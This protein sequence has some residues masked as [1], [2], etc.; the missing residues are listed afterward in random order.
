MA[1]SLPALLVAL[2]LCVPAS[3]WAQYDFGKNRVVYAP[4]KWRIYRTA[5]FDLHY[6]ASMEGVAVELAQVAG[7]GVARLSATMRHRLT[8][9]VPI[10]VYPSATAFANTALSPEVIDEGTGGF[11][12][13]QRDRVVVPFTGK[14][15]EFRHV[16][17]HELAHA[18][19][20]SILENASDGN[21][22]A[23][24]MPGLWAMEGLA[25]FASLGEDETSRAW[26]RD[27]IL[28]E[29]MPGLAE[30]ENYWTLGARAFY[31]YKAG[32][33][34]FAW[35]ARRHGSNAPGEL[36]QRLVRSNDP[37]R[38]FKEVTG[39]KAEEAS[40]LWRQDL[41]ERWWPS[42][43][44]L[45]DPDLRDRRVT[46]ATRDGSS[47]NLRPVFGTN[48]NLVY[49]ISNRKVYAQILLVD[50]DEDRVL[51]VVASADREAAF[52]SINVL[53]NTLSLTADRSRLCFTSRDRGAYV[54]HLWD[55]RSNRQAA[56]YALPMDF[57]AV[58]ESAVSPDGS[59]IAFAA[60]RSNQIDLWL[61]DP[62]APS[63]R[64]LTDDAFVEGEPAWSPDGRHL[65]YTGNRGA[66]KYSTLR[67]LYLRDLATGEDRLLTRG[68]GIHHCPS[69]SPDGKRVAFISDRGGV[70]NIWIKE[71]STG[72]T[73]RVTDLP[74]EALSV[75]W[76]QDG[77][78]LAYG[79]LQAGLHDVFIRNLEPTNAEA[80]LE[81][82]AE[83][84]VA[85]APA[86]AERDRE[87]EA[88][89]PR[90]RLTG[91][92]QNAYRA[93]LV[94]D[95]FMLMAGGASAYGFSL[96]AGASF[97][98]M[99][100]E[101]RLNASLGATYLPGNDY[102]D[103]A[104]YL[105]YRSLKNRVNWGVAGWFSRRNLYMPDL[106]SNYSISNTMVEQNAG[107]SAMAIYPFSKYSRLEASLSPTFFARSFRGTTTE[108]V[109]NLYP[110]HAPT[111]SPQA[112]LAWIF[113]NTLFGYLHPVDNSRA[114]VL[115]EGAPPT[116]SNTGFFRFMA[117][118]RRYFMLGR[119]ASLALRLMLGA[120]VG[121]DSAEYDFKIGGN[122]TLDFLYFTSENY[123]TLHSLPP[124]SLRGNF[125]Q[126][127]NVEYRFQFLQA[128]N[129]SWPFPF[130]IRNI[131]GVV[132]F[133]AGAAT[134]N[135]ATLRAWSSDSNGV[136][137]HDLK[138]A[139]GFGFRFVFLI[140]PMKVDFSTPWDGRTLRDLKNWDV[141][142]S[143]G[144]DY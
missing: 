64:R 119:R 66:T 34:F 50:V 54:F 70:G 25:E 83:D 95:A 22:R 98:D 18:F 28:S 88:Y 94:P 1:R 114:A 140:F 129:F 75:A 48:R 92:S 55:T 89:R 33:S 56:A 6:D 51:R 62:S 96:S 39:R 84:P 139:F 100:G 41:R 47:I 112:R 61:W 128:A 65:A 26:E 36:Y 87:R 5:F 133:D 63:L 29:V 130:S 104:N 17:V 58:F 11:T 40:R 35:V 138:A 103:T 4:I 13:F 21:A 136:T 91:A 49:L 118:G 79:A 109:S 24:R 60:T 80:A 15:D 20:L 117:D 71:L 122:G 111:F 44:T 12:E 132:F 30:L 116:G 23:P 72:A 43:T 143:I 2:L 16:L 46:A 45:K 7:D 126:L 134:T 86:E 120:V 27:G 93:L 81:T 144:F 102:F 135:L 42:V 115:V 142:V 108:L 78:R 105:D 107:A 57:S 82:V 90:M 10:V 141:S 76:D 14:W 85:L 101:H 127:L 131:N 3:L 73:R 74:G 106:Q 99:L 77:K 137:F 124:Y 37:D 52:E 97:S 31:V 59:R 67:D 32:Q 19:E 123:P 113:D 53:N 121:P 8:K 110:I 68:G 69:F 38:A 125:M 9:P